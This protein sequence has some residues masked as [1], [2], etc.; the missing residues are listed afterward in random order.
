M[1]DAS[2]LKFVEE[3]RASLSLINVERKSISPNV[4]EERNI[5]RPHV[6]FIHIGVGSVEKQLAIQLAI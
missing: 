4:V 1:A 2:R 6:G 3:N 5:R